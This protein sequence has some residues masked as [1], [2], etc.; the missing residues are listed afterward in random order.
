MFHPEFE[1]IEAQ[2]SDANKAR[3]EAHH[4][5]VMVAKNGDLPYTRALQKAPFLPVRVVR[6]HR[7]QFPRIVHISLL[8]H[9]ILFLCQNENT[10]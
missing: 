5:M 9:K 8:Q 10:I 3:S 4:D 7:Q 6:F 1:P 2:E